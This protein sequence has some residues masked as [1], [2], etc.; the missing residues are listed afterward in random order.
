MDRAITKNANGATEL[1]VRDLEVGG[2]LICGG[3]LGE[4]RPKYGASWLGRDLTPELVTTPNGERELP[5]PYVLP[6][7][8]NPV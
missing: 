3:N 5:T 4:E 7:E 8:I 6:W 2:N 1:V